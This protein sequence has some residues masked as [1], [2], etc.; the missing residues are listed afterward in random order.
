M[1]YKLKKCKKVTL[2]LLS[3]QETTLSKKL[4]ENFRI[5]SKY[6]TRNRKMPFDMDVMSEKLDPKH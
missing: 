1:L 2:L 3:I 6:F 5:S 4:K